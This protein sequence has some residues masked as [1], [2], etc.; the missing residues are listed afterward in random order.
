MRLSDDMDGDL[1]CQDNVLEVRRIS[2]GWYG[3]FK[4][5]QNENH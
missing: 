2:E 3:T 1:A 5:P 4:R